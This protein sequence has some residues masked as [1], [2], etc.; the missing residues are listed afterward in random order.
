[1]SSVKKNFGYNL[2]LTFCGYLIP[3]ITYP[4][5]SRV[6]GVQ[7]IG[8][9]N[10]VDSVIN[11]FVLF[12]M[13]GIGSFGVREIAR[14]RQ[15]EERRSAV[16]SNL[17]TI[18]ILTTI[19]A[20]VVLMVCTF[21]VPKFAAYKPFLYI[22]VAK[23]IFNVFLIEWLYQG[24]QDFK[25]ITIRSLLVKLIYVGCIFIFIRSKE[26]VLFYY[27]L[28]F[29]STIINALINWIHARKFVHINFH[30]L[31]IRVFLMP[32]ITFGYYRIL[33]SMYTTFNTVFLG[34]SG[35]DVEVGYFATATKLYAII[36]SVFTAF[37][38]VMVP[39]V[40]ELVQEENIE[41]LQ[42][43]A[44]QTISVVSVVCMPII[45][46][47]Q[48]FA[49]DIIRLI[50]GPGYEGAIIPFRIV[51][52]MLLVIGS[53]QILIQQFLMASTKNAPILIT[54]TI[55]AVVG[56]SLNILFTPR[57]GAIGSAIAWGISELAVLAAG[58]FYVKK[59]LGI[60]VDYRNVFVNLLW[61]LLYIL[62]LC[63]VLYLHLSF[64][65][66]LLLSGVVTTVI[67]AVINLYLCKNEQ[68]IDVVH[69]VKKR[70]SNER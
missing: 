17:I 64:W 23:L 4:Y 58:I 32:V 41:K 66:N 52:F 36:M 49:A 5:V 22:G 68:I 9:C 2:L 62:P 47:C 53:E 19:F 65:G 21:L 38:T 37:T 67:F 55:G 56:V 11:Y 54:S 50:A 18:N 30:N 13:L 20:V 60:K 39:K 70:I 28:T 6:L 25:Y 57:M 43:I 69:M 31:D 42:W 46:F 8:I 48:F 40:S 3:L 10:F 44:D 59:N 51:I 16:F 7:N 33:T 1:M 63:G 15:N 12:S 29:L 14:V 34:F 61:S 24:L 45:I 26:D 27:F 35:G